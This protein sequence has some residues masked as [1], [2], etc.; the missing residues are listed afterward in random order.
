M[1]TSSFVV[2][3]LK[4]SLITRHCGG[5]QSS[6]SSQNLDFEACNSI[7]QIYTQFQSDAFYIPSDIDVAPMD[8]TKGLA[9]AFE[10]AQAGYDEGGIPV[11]FFTSRRHA[12]S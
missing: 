3:E 1:T 2:E 6:Y 4:K 10:E 7:Q 12:Q 11:C 5:L 8:D 9:I